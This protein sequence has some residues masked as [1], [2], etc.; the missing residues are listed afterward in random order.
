[1]CVRV[2]VLCYLIGGGHIA[3]AA[4]FSSTNGKLQANGVPFHLKG[5]IWRGAEG[6]GDLPEGLSGAHAHSVQHYARTLAAGGF[7]AVRININHQAVL[8]APLV[9]HFDAQAEPGLIDKRYLQALQFIMQEL[10]AQGLLVALACTRLAPHD[11]PGNGLWHS[12]DVPEEDVLRSWTKITNFLCKQDNLFAVDLFDAPHGATWG[13]GGPT[14]D[15]HGAAERIGNHVLAGCPRLLVMVQGARSVPWVGHSSPDL[16]PGLNLM[17]VRERRIQLHDPTKLV[18][19]P[20]LAPPNEHMLPAY[21]GADFPQAMPLVWGRQFGYVTE[22]TSSAI[23][24]ARAGGLLDDALDRTWQEAL[25][26]WLREREIGFFYDCLNP[27]PSTGGLLHKDWSALRQM[28][29]L[30]LNGLAATRLADL[31]VQRPISSGESRIRP[32]EPDSAPLPPPPPSELV[33]I[34]S[35]RASGLRGALDWQHGGESSATLL[36]IFT[37]NDVGQAWARLL[38]E[39]AA[40]IRDHSV[41][42]TATGELR[43]RIDFNRSMCFPSIAARHGP[44]P[45]LCFQIADL[46]RSGN[47]RYVNRGCGLLQRDAAR[48]AVALNDGAQLTVQVSFRMLDSDGESTVALSGTVAMLLALCA[49]VG[50]ISVAS[51]R[52]PRAWCVRVAACRERLLLASAR[53]L[54]SIGF[55]ALAAEF[56]RS[57]SNHHSPL[58]R[59][60]PAGGG[61]G[62]GRAAGSS[63]IHKS[64]VRSDSRAALVRSTF[65]ETD[66]DAARMR[67]SDDRD[68]DAEAMMPVAAEVADHEEAVKRAMELL[69]RDAAPVD[70]RIATVASKQHEALR[71]RGPE[72]KTKDLPSQSSTLLADIATILSQS[73]VLT[74]SRAY[75]GG[76]ETMSEAGALSADLATVGE[77]PAELLAEG[78]ERPEA[79]YAR[80]EVS[81]TSIIQGMGQPANPGSE[82]WVGRPQA[83]DGE[84]VA[85]VATS[86]D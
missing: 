55:G 53:L 7:N 14:V 1:M 84:Q 22:A 64:T 79:Y 83:S 4:Q 70:N 76:Y 27:N 42:P 41:H 25:F 34:E 66:A 69:Q 75:D 81:L 11:A 52:M 63:S 28:K 39:G 51:R 60:D 57:A 54:Y 10:S 2:C 6:P 77:L 45:V 19:S 46:A 37:G 62:A 85:V 33:C 29:L 47:V 35:A 38:Y 24:V 78:A 61:K 73:D 9:T 20:S 23:I 67:E 18:Y 72:V 31:P 44:G 13:F 32:V 12:A 40:G 50:A 82:A 58:A 68:E 17:G 36:S 43:Q 30:L 8:D 26:A 15:W 56:S 16:P 86:M 80:S 21:R 3:E 49:I 59:L 74:G 48:A 71:A 5:A 65:Q